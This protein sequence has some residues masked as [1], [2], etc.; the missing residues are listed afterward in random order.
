[1]SKWPSNSSDLSPIEI[2]RSI[3]KGMLTMFPP[4]NLE[5]LKQQ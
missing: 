5:E 3:I 1:M 4:I 2:I